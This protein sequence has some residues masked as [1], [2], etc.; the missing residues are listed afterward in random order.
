MTPIRAQAKTLHTQISDAVNLAPEV[1]QDYSDRIQKQAKNHPALTALCEFSATMQMRRLRLVPPTAWQV[2][3][4]RWAGQ[5]LAKLA[6]LKQNPDAAATLA[7]ACL[8]YQRDGL[9]EALELLGTPEAA[10]LIRDVPPPLPTGQAK[11]KRGKSTTRNTPAFEPAPE[12]MT[13]AEL[14]PETEAQL[15]ALREETKKLNR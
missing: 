2:L 10:E 11:P 8:G 12:G 1:M 15:A 14:D 3:E 5:L 6:E 9:E 4:V 7:L 13:E